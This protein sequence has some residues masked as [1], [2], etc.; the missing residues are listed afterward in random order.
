MAGGT[1]RR[2]RIPDLLSIPV[3]PPPINDRL[4]PG[5]WEGNLI[6]G[7]G[8]ACA[9]GVRVERTRRRVLLARMDDAASALAGFT[10]QLNAITEPMRHRLTY[11]QGRQ[12]ARHRDLT[13]ATQ[14]QVTFCE[15]HS[16][17]QRGTCASPAG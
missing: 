4:L 12:M 10:A 13:C 2:G 17:G 8:N 5:H 9:V 14:V 11:D 15:P 7:A 3:R 1:D 6:R 16:P